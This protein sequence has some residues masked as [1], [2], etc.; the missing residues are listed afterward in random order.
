MCHT[1]QV[2]QRTISWNVFSY[3]WE[4]CGS[5]SACQV[6]LK[7]TLLL[8][9]LAGTRWKKFKVNSIK[10]DLEKKY[11]KIKYIA[12]G[13]IKIPFQLFSKNDNQNEC[14]TNEKTK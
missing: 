4:F 5:N 12:E 1:V 6:W 7:I 3:H 2:G 9:H 14:D 10:D 8:S 13:K 11:K